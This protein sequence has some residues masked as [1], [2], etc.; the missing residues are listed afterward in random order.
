M[1]PVAGASRQ[2]HVSTSTPNQSHEN[3]LGLPRNNQRI[4]PTIPR[5][6]AGPPQP[7]H[8]P[9]VKNIVCVS[10]GKGGVGKSTISTN[11][12]IAL[13]LT[14]APS[15]RRKPQ[16]VGLLDLD[17]FGPSIPK[18]MG[19]E[20]M[21]E[22]ELT[23]Y[24]G[25]IPMKNHGVS[26]MSMGLLLGNNDTKSEE[27]RVVT[28]RGMMVMKATQQLLFDVDWRLDPRAPLPCSPEA[29]DENLNPGLDI[30][31]I[32]MPPGTGDVALS[33]A[34]LVKVDTA[35]VVTTPQQ[36]AL[37]DAKKG[38]SMFKKTNVPMAGLVLNMSHFVSPDTGKIFQLFGNSQAV[39][40]Y[41]ERQAL[42]VLARIPLQPQLSIGGDEGIPAILRES[43]PTF[44]VGPR[45]SASVQENHIRKAFLELAGKI[46][47]QLSQ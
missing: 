3:P 28:W 16:R 30:L 4:P 7:R 1:Q 12:A 19:L 22:P 11:L 13:S 18:L 38:V 26:C 20:G 41:A 15:S 36:V 25:L 21:G 24:G 31:V 34:Q 39:D 40:E 14:N 17:I 42:Q 2:R 43:L 10:S 35:I 6:G 47:S 37:L 32:D 27:D 45:E 8:I 46:W 29:L 9:N 33:L 23:E 44:Q 5:R